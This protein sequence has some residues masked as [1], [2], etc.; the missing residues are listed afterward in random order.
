MAGQTGIDTIYGGPDKDTIF[1]YLGN[2]FLYGEGENDTIYGGEDSD[3]HIEGG[4]GDD[5]LKGEGG[6]DTIWGDDGVD[7][8]L[9]GDDNDTMY[10]GLLVDDLDG[11]AG[12]DTM[13][14]DEGEDALDGGEDSDEIHGGADNDTLDGGDGEFIDHLFGEGGDDTLDGGDG[15]DLIYGDDEFGGVDPGDDTLTGG[16]GLDMLY[17]G[18]GDDLLDGGEDIDTLYGDGDADTLRG[19]TENDTLLGGAGDDCLFGEEGDDSL[20]GDGG[21]DHLYAGSGIDSLEGGVGA[22]TLVSIDDDDTDDPGGA[23]TSTASGSTSSGTV[24]FAATTDTVHDADSNEADYSLHEVKEFENGADKS[25][26]G[27]DIFEPLG[28]TEWRDYTGDPLF[29]SAGPTYSDVKQGDLADC[30]LLSSLAA[31]A[32]A[33]PEAI[34]QLVVDLG[35]G[36]FAVELSGKQ[37]RVDSEFAVFED[38]P[39]VRKYAKGGNERSL[40]VAVVEEAFAMKRGNDYENLNNDT[41]L[42]C[43][44]T[45]GGEDAL[46]PAFTSPSE[47]LKE[48]NVPGIGAVFCT[49]LDDA[50]VSVLTSGHCYAIV[51]MEFDSVG[52]PTDVTLYNPY[53]FGDGTDDGIVT[54]TIGELEHDAQAPS[55]IIYADF[56]QYNWA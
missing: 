13:Y 18:D 28:G 55:P 20:Y 30:W 2:D 16:E 36:T 21:A 32:H 38:N 9:G 37:Y 44:S 33:S 35:D 4:D 14:G 23:P 1:G 3:D 17:G 54:L 12:N 22:D 6:N 10:G 52:E 46:F 11:G 41:P 43:L 49:D 31:A 48:I 53:G 42:F 8:L 56:T 39:D 5:T 34:R 15:D 7:I 29:A 26:D 45:M 24:S 25:L 40:W 47:V 50:D 51:G 27:D 19:G